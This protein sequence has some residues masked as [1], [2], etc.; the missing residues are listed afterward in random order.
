L[1]FLFFFFFFFL[2]CPLKVADAE[3][4]PEST[5]DKHAAQAC[6]SEPHVKDVSGQGFQWKVDLFCLRSRSVSPR[7][8]GSR[9]CWDDGCFG[10]WRAAAAVAVAVAAA[11]QPSAAGRVGGRTTD[12]RQGAGAC[13]L[14]SADQ[15]GRGKRALLLLFGPRTRNLL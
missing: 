11:R 6:P 14:T 7:L 10:C 8:Q 4:R 2:I 15:G 3:H 9:S 12:Q 5:N 1:F 13:F